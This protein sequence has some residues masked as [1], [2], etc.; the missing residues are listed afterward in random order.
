M[1]IP[2]MER[3]RAFRAI[4]GSQDPGTGFPSNMA[5]GSLELDADLLFVPAK[6]QFIALL[7][8]FWIF[9]ASSFLPF[10]FFLLMC[11]PSFSLRK[12]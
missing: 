10:D 8:S 3:G 12:A 6:I 1:S 5:P 9:A 7:L 11:F 2:S 4:S